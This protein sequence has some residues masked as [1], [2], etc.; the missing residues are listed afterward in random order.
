M[1][2]HKIK[3]QIKKE[4]L[5][6]AISCCKLQNDAGGVVFLEGLNLFLDKNGYLT[7]KQSLALS[8]KIE[9]LL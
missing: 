2:I 8:R 5:V 9:W 1:E 6:T 7:P 3:A 4:L